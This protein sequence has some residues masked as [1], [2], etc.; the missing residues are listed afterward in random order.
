M[1]GVRHFLLALQFFTRVPVTGPLAAWVGFSPQM[2]RASAAHL[3]GI[4][5]LVGGVAALVFTGVGMG[6]P[7]VAGALAAALLSTVATVMLTGAFH[8]D[9]LADVADGL[10]GS[11]DRDRAL[12]IMK[13]SRIGAFGAIALVLALGLK[14]ALLAVLTGRGLQTV[15]VA[16]VG[17]HVLSR[18]MPL[19]LIRWL[20]YVGD[21]GASKAKPLA[22]AISGGA[23]VIALVWTVPAV[24]LL[25]CAHDAVQVGAAVLAT[26]L[27]AGW[28]ARLFLRRL[29]GFTG[30][31][32]GATQQVCELTI[33][34]ALAWRA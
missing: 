2:L 31:G 13:D 7:G 33:Y 29:Q 30:D 8:E 24:A 10:G 17:A 20:P 6:L 27:V 21:S 22:D 32:L 14:C 5:W 15:A 9:G 34:L 11:A 4:G 12:E 18:L 28:M 26:V 19:F 16:I 1:N 25:L 3:P 23:L